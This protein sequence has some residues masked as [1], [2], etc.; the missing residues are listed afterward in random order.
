MTMTM[1]IM[2]TMMNIFY[3]INLHLTGLAQDQLSAVLT[4]FLILKNIRETQCS[5]FWRNL[6]KINSHQTEIL[7]K[8]ERYAHVILYL[9]GP[10]SS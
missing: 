1:T 6:I 5:H 4:A 9:L 8:K 10:N 7:T 3:V 2:M